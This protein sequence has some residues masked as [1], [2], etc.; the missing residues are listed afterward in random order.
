MDAGLRFSLR[1]TMHGMNIEF[2]HDEAIRLLDVH[3]KIIKKIAQGDL[4]NDDPR[5]TFTTTSALRRLE[6]LKGE[7][8]KVRNLE[9]VVAVIGT[10]K[11][12]KSTTINAIVGAEIV[13]A[14]SHPMTALPTMIRHTPGRK[15]PRLIFPNPEPLNALIGK[16]SDRL[17]TPPSSRDYADFV[18]AP[19]GRRLVEEIRNGTFAAMDR[20]AEGGEA[21]A[22]LL[23]HVN[24]LVRLARVAD[25]P[26]PYDEYDEVHEFPVIEVEFCHLPA[27]GGKG[28]FTLLD[29]PGPNEA[30]HSAALTENLRRQLKQSSAI[31]VVMD[32]TQLNSEA[33]ANIRQE[34]AQVLG[35]SQDPSR[36]YV[37]V[38]KYDQKTRNDTV[39]VEELR[40]QLAHRLS[41]DAG[42]RRVTLSPDQIFL[43]SSQRAFLA[44]RVI[45][46]M[47]FQE[48][49][50]DEQPWIED[51][52]T[53]AFGASWE[54]ADLADHDEVRNRAASLFRK[55][56][57]Q[58]PLD[59]VIR[60]GHQF[61]AFNS[62]RS[63]ARKLEH[64]GE[65]VAGFIDARSTGLKKDA[66]ELQADID[67]LEGDIQTI[68]VLEQESNEALAAGMLKLKKSCAQL[69][70]ESC[71]GLSNQ[72]KDI[73][74][75][76]ARAEAERQRDAEENIRPHS[77]RNIF[78]IISMFTGSA[79]GYRSSRPKI[80]ERMSRGTF[81]GQ[82]VINF[83]NRDDAMALIR[84]VREEVERAIMAARGEFVDQV[85]QAKER[86]IAEIGDLIRNRATPLFDEIRSRLHNAGYEE[87][88]LSLIDIRK[89]DVSAKS[90]KSIDVTIVEE[91]ETQKVAQSGFGFVKRLFGTILFQD[92][93]GYDDVSKSYYP[94]DLNVLVEKAISYLEE[95][96]KSVNSTMNKYISVEIEKKQK[97]FFDDMR[98]KI[99]KIRGDLLASKADKRKLRDA[100]QRI[101]ELL[102]AQKKILKLETVALANF[103]TALE[104]EIQ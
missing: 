34:L 5:Q 81:A 67:G 87:I 82:G 8:T 23:R 11:A 61:A 88:R 56:G 95:Y 77:I 1:D 80:N 54:E 9:M 17:A 14:R 55:S 53:M 27:E 35:G 21:I 73:F 96:I 63:A 33:D 103:L 50:P 12:G 2:L 10:M 6:E 68:M 101:L 59:K 36:V 83:S 44:N 94:V 92:D 84:D 4:L 7:S 31:L 78:N 69:F 38:N 25:L 86:Y 29:T 58:A 51:F 16:L 70:S 39:T 49:N 93:W 22:S 98:S 19:D 97:D 28:Q 30:G 47:D 99:E 79:P 3:Q 20:M 43:V 71:L 91:K 62:L 90:V 102:S 26:F 75:A 66:T 45:R 74:S 57:F 85:D 46:S 60:H 42:E 48:F 65:E 40:A 104:Q 72:I 37:I 52:A 100:Q 89:I 32:F 15:V 41:T 18:A 76:E 13:P 64:N 24:D